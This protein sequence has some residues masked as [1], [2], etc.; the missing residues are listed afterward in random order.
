[1]LL[2]ERD[3]WIERRGP[4]GSEQE[5]DYCA[6]RG[7]PLIDPVTAIKHILRAVHW[8]QPVRLT[9]REVGEDGAPRIRDEIVSR[10]EVLHA[11]S[12]LPFPLRECIELV[13]IQSKSRS[14]AAYAL[15]MGP[16][17]LDRYI[18]QAFEILV[19]IIFDYAPGANGNQ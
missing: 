2:T 19:A 17:S 3:R 7:L 6:Q 13:Y 12:R 5:R 18:G 8:D 16:R 1:M 10:V 4:I 15:G 11:V 9:S 14:D